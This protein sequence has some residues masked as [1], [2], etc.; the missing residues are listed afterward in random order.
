M[1][2]PIKQLIKDPDSL[3]S[4]PKTATVR[5]AL[6]S[7]VEND[8]SQLPVRNEQ[9]NL[10]GLISESSITN[11]YFHIGAT[12]SL[13]DLTVDHCMA[14]PRTI[15]PE[16]DI[17]EALNMLENVYAVVVV[18]NQKPVGILTDYD[19]TH[20]FR[21]LTEG[22][23]IIQD[24]EVTLRQYIDV[25]FPD[26]HRMDAALM[27]AFKE[28]KKDPT[29]PAKEYGEL[30]FGEHIQL[31]VT[32]HNWGKFSE[33]FTP[34]EL[35]TNLMLQVGDVRNQL[36]HFRGGLEPIQLNAL[37]RGRDWLS[38]RP[39]P[40]SLQKEVVDRAE[41]S[42][43][44]IQAVS[45]SE[46]KY[47]QLQR[48]LV[49]QRETGQPRIR[50]GFDQIEELL[51]NKFPDSA[52]KHRSWWTNQPGTHF[53][54]GSWVS[55]GWV[56]DD[57]D[58]GAGEVTFR[59]TNQALYYTFF[60]DLLSSLKSI[61]PGITQTQRASLQNWLSFNSGIA[62]FAFA[63]VLPKEPILRV[64][65]YIDKG[66]KAANKAALEALKVQ[67]DEIEAEIGEKLV[68]SPL[69]KARAS[70]IYASIPFHI[71]HSQAEHEQAKHWGVEMMLKFN[72]VFRPRLRG[73]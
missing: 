4:V 26:S 3:L 69:P 19:T 71:T 18:E 44:G 15:S 8:F 59:K 43:D 31:I 41:I 45:T 73:L 5:E 49:M 22:L 30:S 12:L 24:I 52:R 39:K 48:W 67:K 28:N 61:R 2:F 72:D 64:E 13:L 62:G 38:T 9:G 27:R 32:E 55:A 57:V 54:S 68:W 51:G 33:Y 66:D 46:D 50:L 56:V 65:L 14:S 47:D 21:D 25:V 40:A 29:R 37:L 11:T 1:L 60:S 63:W 20:F 17:F 42:F 36:A 58:L 16:A 70:R 6:T 10:I 7:M 34:K 23:I 53:Q 35:F